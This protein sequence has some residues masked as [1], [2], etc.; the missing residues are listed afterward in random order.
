MRNEIV[1][2]TLE[3]GVEGGQILTISAAGHILPEWVYEYSDIC[4]KL[5]SNWKMIKRYGKEQK[6]NTAM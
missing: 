1:W 6:R 2:I 5:L 4:I 3:I